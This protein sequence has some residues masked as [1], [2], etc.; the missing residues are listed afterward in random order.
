M[1]S[2]GPTSADLEAVTQF[3][4]GTARA[5]LVTRRK[6]GGLQSSPMSV[7]ADDDGQHHRLFV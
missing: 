5:V 3:A 4:A 6:D 1:A 2:M 7:V